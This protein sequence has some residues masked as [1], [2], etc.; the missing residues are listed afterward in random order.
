MATEIQIREHLDTMRSLPRRLELL[1]RSLGTVQW[2][3]QGVRLNFPSGTEMSTEERVLV[4]SR[5]SDLEA[6]TT[7]ANLQP[8]ECSKARLSLLTK[9]L[10]GYPAAGAHTE[11][12]AEARVGFYQEA[13]ADIAPWALDAAIKRWVRGDVANTNVDFAPSPGALRRLC[14]TELEPYRVVMTKLRRLQ[15]AV[16]IERAMDPKPIVSAGRAI[17]FKSMSQAAE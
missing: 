2:P 16:S 12:A 8:A 4:E 14:E 10:L 15:S 3:G 5:L 1:E 9:L 13:V 11:K 17:G 6:I 7:G